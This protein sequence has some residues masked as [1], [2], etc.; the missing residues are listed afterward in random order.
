MHRSQLRSRPFLR[1]TTLRKALAI[2][3]AGV[4]AAAFAITGSTPA[5]AATTQT[6]SCIDGSGVRWTAKATWGSTYS[7]GGVS[8]V[9]I[10]YAGWTANRAGTLRTDS[11]VRTYDGAGT[12]LSTLTWTGP[13]NYATSTAY[14][15]RNPVDP[16]SA[17]GAAKVT[18]TLGVDGDG[19]GNCALTFVQPG[20]ATP[21][22]T[23]A[24]DKYEADVVSDQPGADRTRHRRAQRSGLREQLRQY[25]CRPDGR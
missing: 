17:P 20:T 23:S 22:G 24:S 3:A 2:G 11:W 8:K 5:V 19:L 12:L 1:A 4:L 15:A 18:V 14:K 7:A 16:P 10:D 9:V 6:A 21:P 13:F 25:P